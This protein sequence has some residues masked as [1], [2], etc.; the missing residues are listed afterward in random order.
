MD[1][2]SCLRMPVDINTW[3]AAIG[4]IWNVIMGSSV[5]YFTKCHRCILNSFLLLQVTLL[6]LFMVHYYNGKLGLMAFLSLRVDSINTKGNI[7]SKSSNKC[8]TT[9]H[10]RMFFCSLLFFI[11]MI[12]LVLFGDIE[13]N[14]GLD[15][16]YSNSFFFS[17]RNLNII[18]AH[19]FI[20][21][22][23]LQAYNS[24]HRYDIICL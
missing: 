10:V 15:P 9:S 4:L 17:H 24:V 5:F 2:L 21:I 14:P 8:C 7:S 1:V 22:S 16:G 13:T 23:L 6:L 19:N 3:R 20:K 12:L 11:S 18:S